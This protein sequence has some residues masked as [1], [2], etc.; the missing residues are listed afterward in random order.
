MGL[1]LYSFGRTELDRPFNAVTTFAII[2]WLDFRRYSPAV[3]RAT[4]WTLV[5]ALGFVA[6]AFVVRRWPNRPWMATAAAAAGV[7]V[8]FVWQ[9]GFVKSK[10]I[11]SLGATS[12]NVH[13]LVGAIDAQH[14]DQ[15]RIDPSIGVVG[16]L[17]LAYWLPRV[18]IV[19]GTPD[20]EQCARGLTVSRAPAPGLTLVDRVGRFNLYRG[21]VAC[22]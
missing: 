12:A 7:T 17:H 14:V 15:L 5:L 10:V 20:T 11:K 9:L 6:I 8:L 3:F 18:D 19:A 1:I 13:A 21:H 2:G 16:R 4:A 22:P